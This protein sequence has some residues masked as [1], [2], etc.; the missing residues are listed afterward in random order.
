MDQKAINVVKNLT[1]DII[2]NSG[3]EGGY[4][5]C[6]SSAPIL[7]TL[8][9]RH[10]NVNPSVSDWINR[11]RFVLSASHASALLYATMFLSGYPLM[12]DDLKTYKQFGSSLSAYPDINTF[13]VDI[14]TGALGEGLGMAVGMALAEK[15]YEAL[16]NQGGKSKL[17][18][19]IDYKV[20]V[21][22]SDGDLM[23]GVSYEA[24]SFAGAMGLNNLIVLYDSNDVSGDGD[25]KR[26]FNESVTS[27]FSAMGWNT[28]F[29]KNGNSVSEI[30]KAIEKAKKSQSPTLIQIKTI[31]GE[32]LLNQGTSITH[33]QLL[34]KNDLDNFKQKAG[35]GTIPFTILKEP[36][37]YMR[38]QVVNRSIKIYGDWENL[39]NEYKKVLNPAQLQEINNINQ[40]L[41][42]ID[43]N[44][45]E[46]PIDY[47]KKEPMRESNHR[48]MNII[49]DSVYN[50]IGGSADLANVTKVHLDNQEDILYNKYSGKNI[51]FGVRDHF[52]GSCLNGLAA[53]GFR[54]F[55]S[56]LM[57]FSDDM[58]IPIRMS[59][60]MDLPITYIFTHDS[61]SLSF[62][63]PTHEPVEQ[64]S[65]LRAIP[66]LYVFRPAD[67][68]EI[69]GTWNV[70]LNN[71]FPAVI[72]LARNEIK[73]EQG[74]S[75]QSVSKGAYVAGEEKERIDAVIIAT[76]SEVQLAKSIQVKLLEKNIDVRIVSM[77]CMELYNIQD[78]AYKESIIPSGKPIF[79]LEF[80]SSF[81]WE[82][83]V[84]SSDYLLTVDTF[85]KC[86]SKESIN[87]Y[88][89]INI[90]QL[91]KRI[92]NLL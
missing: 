72:S 75:S 5:I 59:A 52:M 33:S 88:L 3:S 79:V 9:T 78:E 26:T 13:G 8:F 77:P 87:T 17:G 27:R 25:I 84:P 65:S 19:L 31:I 82:K 24:A 35:V 38:D 54:S 12:I 47:D 55:G 90:D 80:A 61:A 34:E 2:Q 37:S 68:K 60:I 6:F 46:I 44:R 1:L 83:F 58:K 49:G 20:Y 92:E 41:V 32:G 73:A 43:L 15:K 74:T 7:Y 62:E 64:L 40:N 69:I 67:I 71:K 45:A 11:D 18:K 51:S 28:I 14:S 53:S 42:N 91:I 48:I 30:S 29:V 81:G 23:K 63:G 66:N 21:L 50:F 57:S 39:F 89:N 4:G 16:Y 36:A 10:L 70:I 76:G 22:A 56:T 85:S 86:G